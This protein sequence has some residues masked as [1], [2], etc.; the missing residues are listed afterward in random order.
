MVGVSGFNIVLVDLGKCFLREE[1]DN[2]E[3]IRYFHGA[4][5]STYHHEKE[6]KKSATTWV[7]L[8]KVVILGDSLD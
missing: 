6:Q 5:L 4:L 1:R 2:S 8:Y 7:A 3:G